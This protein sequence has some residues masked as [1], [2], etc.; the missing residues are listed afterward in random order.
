MKRIIRLVEQGKLADAKK[1]VFNQ[2]D[3]NRDELLEAAMIFAHDDP[4]NLNEADMG[5][6]KGEFKKDSDKEGADN[7][8]KDADTKD[9]DV[10]K[11]KED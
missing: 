11:K 7:V 8:D 5:G 6:D 2:M 9:Q 10:K 4:L 3:K 1:L